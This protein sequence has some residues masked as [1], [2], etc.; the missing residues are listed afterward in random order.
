MVLLTEQFFDFVIL[1]L[2]IP[3]AG[4]APSKAFSRALIGQLNSGRLVLPT[5][6][7]GLTEFAEVASDE[8][9]FYDANL[10]ALE[11]FSWTDDTWADRLSNRVTYL[12]NSK[13]SAHNFQA[14]NYDLDVFALVARHQSEFLPVKEV[15]FG[16]SA[17]KGISMP[18]WNVETAFGEIDLGSGRTL[19]GCVACVGEMGIGPTSAATAQ[20]ISLFRPRLVAMLGMCCGFNSAASAYPQKLGNVV[21]VREVTC[22]EEGKFLDSDESS[23][24]RSRA[25]TR[26]VSDRLRRPVELAIEQGR[27]GMERALSQL[28]KKRRFQDI[29]Q[30]YSPLLDQDPQVR[31]GAV[32]TGSSFVASEEK[33]A[34]II[35]LH[36]TAM[37]LDM[38]VFGLY[39]APDFVIGSKPL[40]LAAKGVADFGDGQD[41]PELQAIAS[42]S[43]AIVF[44]KILAHI[45][46]HSLV[47]E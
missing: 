37:G 46:L 13:R 44:K 33:V 9:T 31:F 15:L 36:P 30:K 3:G 29:V 35:E 12:V 28:R 10:F 24:F 42:A 5:I 40:C 8:R 43:A 7:V 23:E 34:E 17:S 21:V 19:S 25:K 6:V 38:E 11:L 39:T 14:Y 41:K 26:N 47:S 1:D 2:L 32:V 45:D 27:E 20:A 4:Q 16:N 18:N 22:W